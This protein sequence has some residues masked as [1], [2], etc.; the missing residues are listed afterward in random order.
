MEF[1]RSTTFIINIV[2]FVIYH[3]IFMWAYLW[4]YYSMLRR[5]QVYT[6]TKKQS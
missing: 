4:I 6:S 2:L 1:L 3:N 5:C